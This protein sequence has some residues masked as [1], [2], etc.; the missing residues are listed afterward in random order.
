VAIASVLSANPE[1]LV[2]DE[3]TAGLDARYREETVALLSRLRD[4]GRTIVTVTHDFEMAFEHSDRLLV[5]DD[6]RKVCEGSVE[7]VLPAMLQAGPR[8]LLP[9]LVQVTAL[10][11]ARGFDTPLTW[12]AEEILP[13]LP[14]LP[15]LPGLPG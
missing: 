1:C 10:L 12:R 7:D 4:L 5:M 15:Y 8:F 3:P 6:G 9:D 11:R 2:L 14:S 13:S